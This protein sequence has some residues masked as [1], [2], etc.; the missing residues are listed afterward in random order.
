[1][2]GR[3]SVLSCSYVLSPRAG[4][5]SEGIMKPLAAR[6]KSGIVEEKRLAEVPAM[7]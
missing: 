7:S 3:R 5:P 4:Q 2:R 1:M 6:V